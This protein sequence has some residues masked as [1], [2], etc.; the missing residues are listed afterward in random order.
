MLTT[1]KRSSCLAYIVVA[2]IVASTAPAFAAEFRFERKADWDSWAF[3]RG[4]LVQN[5]D[6]SIGLSRIDRTINAVANA[7]DFLHTIKSSKEPI[8]GGIRVVGASAATAVNIIDGRDDTWWAPDQNV[9]LEDWWVEVDLGRM[10]LAKKIRLTFPDTLDVRPF[11]NFSVY[12]NDGVRATASKDVFQFT[13]VGLTTAPNTE[14]VVEYELSTVWPGAATGEY[15][16]TRDTLDHQMVQYVRFVAE[17]QHPGAALA[18]VEVESL[19]DNAVLGSI[20]RGGGVRGGTDLTNLSTLIDGDKNSTWSLSGPNDWIAEGHWLEIDLGATYWIDRAFMHISRTRNFFGS[21]EIAT[22]DGAQAVGVT[23]DRVRSNFDFQQLTQ[24]DNIASPL[25]RVFDFQFP[26]RKVRYG[27]YHRLNYTRIAGASGGTNNPFYSISEFMLFGAGYVA[28]AEMESDFIDLGGTKSI[29]KLSWDAE[30]PPGTFIEIR[31]QTGDTFLIE[32]KFYNK[33]GIEISQAQWNKLPKSQKQDIVAIQRKGSDWS[34]WSQVYAFPEEI[35]LSPTPRRF[36]QLQVKLG[37]DNPEVAPLLRHIALHF[38]DALVSGGVT[39]RILPRQ[40]GFDSLQ[41]FTYVL[42]PTFRAG[43]QGFDRVHIQT[44]FAVEAVAVKVGGER[45]VPASVVMVADSLQVDLPQL[46]QR[47]SV[48]I[49]FQTRVQA[50]ATAFDAWVSLA[51]AQLQQGTRP[52]A[53][54]AVTVF[55]PSVASG[56]ALIRLVEVTPLLTPNGDGIND[57]AS[58]R[59]VLAKVEATLPEVAIYDLSGRRV[60]VVSSGIDGFSWDGRDGGGQLLAP[61]AYI[62]RIALAVDVGEQI[63]QRIINLAY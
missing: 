24:V 35:F 46:V 34:G 4:A 29:R 13:R 26:L 50:N 20:K 21:F 5:E 52:E 14:R 23:A 59:F 19:G 15:L 31:S 60:R 42:K 40:V 45:V 38:D 8:P 51:S 33:N 57:E 12:V 39:S 37:N 41:T 6:G 63:A 28:G 2:L 27:F 62:C 1:N 54:H 58:I 11:R 9:V 48:E 30:L 16:V 36:V 49:Q 3:P 43:D 56:G 32:E 22:S 17:E 44:P 61:G 7:G 47:D 53:Q 55:V 18:M 10:V 25:R